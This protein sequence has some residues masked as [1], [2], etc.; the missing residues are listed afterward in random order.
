MEFLIA[1]DAPRIPHK[2][3]WQ[4]CVGSGHALLALRTDYTRQLKLIHDTLGIQRVRFHGI[5]CDDMRP[6]TDLSQ[7]FPAPGAEDF[8]RIQ[9]RRAGSR[10]RR[11]MAQER[12]AGPAPTMRMSQ[13][14]VTA[15]SVLAKRET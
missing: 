14:G 12:P 1:S 6:R 10:V 7:M 11:R 5:F 8:S 3:H 13:E 9:T 2:K 4:F 15:R